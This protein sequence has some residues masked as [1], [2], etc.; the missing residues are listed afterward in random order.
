MFPVSLVGDDEFEQPEFT[1]V[2]STGVGQA[3]DWLED[4]SVVSLESLLLDLKYLGDAMVAERGMNRSM[5]LEAHRVM[6]E[7]AQ[8]YPL[9]YFTEETTQ[10]NY[11]PA[12]EELHTAVWAA[13]GAAAAAIAFLLYK[14]V[15]WI[16]S[17]LTGEPVSGSNDRP[18]D[19]EITSSIKEAETKARDQA[20][21]APEFAK[22]LQ[23]S[24]DENKAAGD[25]IGK[26]MPELKAALVGHS[27]DADGATPKDGDALEPENKGSA[28]GAPKHPGERFNAEDFKTQEDFMVAVLRRNLGDKF[29]PLQRLE[30]HAYFDI[31]IG[32]PWSR[33]ILSL[34]PIINSLEGALQQRVSAMEAFFTADL[35]QGNRLDIER[36]KKTVEQ[37]MTSLLTPGTE[38]M[39]LEHFARASHT[40]KEV[41]AVNKN[42]IALDPIAGQVRGAAILHDPKYGQLLEARANAMPKLE[43]IHQL[44]KRMADVSLHWNKATPGQGQGAGVPMDISH[45]VARA[46]NVLKNDIRYFSTVILQVQNFLDLVDRFQGEIAE[47]FTQYHALVIRTSRQVGVEVDVPEQVIKGTRILQALRNKFGKPSPSNR[48]F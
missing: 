35:T 44:E 36:A 25:T 5:A 19:S 32:G 42:N 17:K 27:G 39:D 31:Y 1:L 16:I 11:R 20:K 10:T 15:R 18:S 33:R 41:M 22:A 24:A 45:M 3:P 28:D 38:F 30:N 40:F 2:E 8:K 7:F 13:I 12:L 23:Q 47:M 14:F 34:S 37:F 9:G 6:P 21:Q 4:D 29:G 43:L 46:S 48:A 26:A